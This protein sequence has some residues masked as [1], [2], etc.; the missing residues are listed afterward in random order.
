MKKKYEILNFNLKEL[1]LLERHLNKM[2]NN[3]WHLKWISNFIIC[4]EYSEDEIHYYIDFN[5]FSFYD[6][7]K[8]DMRKE[9][10]N[11]IA[12]YED[13]GYEFVCSFDHY[14]I[15]KSK[16]LLEKIHTNNEIQN[17]AF[18]YVKNRTTRYHLYIILCYLFLAVWIAYTSPRTLLL[19]IFNLTY[20]IVFLSFAISLYFTYISFKNKREIELNNI[21]RRSIIY[22]SLTIVQCVLLILFALFFKSNQVLFGILPGYYFVYNISNI[23]Y[24]QSVDR[25]YRRIPL[26]TRYIPYYFIIVIYILG[27]YFNQPIDIHYPHNENYP[28]NIIN[29]EFFMVEPHVEHYSEYTSIALDMIETRIANYDEKEG[30]NVF[31]YNDKTGLLKFLILHTSAAIEY[32]DIKIM[33]N[34]EVR[35]DDKHNGMTYLTFINNNQYAHVC[36]SEDYTNETIQN[37]INSINWK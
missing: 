2:A 28:Q 26:M 35:Y 5:Q 16:E 10:E 24:F 6:K 27:V 23:I 4:Y 8:E 13:L 9:A 22:F 37:L 29:T 3:H 18:K 20:P 1:D 11:Q 25:K 17:E 14:A 30:A 34:I 15:Y 31:Y 32:D 12:F 19:S 36:I 7:E 21:K 33:N